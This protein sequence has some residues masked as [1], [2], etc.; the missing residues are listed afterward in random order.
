M[1]V[2]LKLF[3]AQLIWKRDN[4]REAIMNDIHQ[5]IEGKLILLDARR[6]VNFHGAPTATE[7]DAKMVESQSTA[8]SSGAYL[9]M[10]NLT[11]SEKKLYNSLINYVPQG[12]LDG[13]SSSQ[14]LAA[15]IRRNSRVKELVEADIA[16][17]CDGELGLFDSS[18][19]HV[20]PAAKQKSDLSDTGQSSIATPKPTIKQSHTTV[21][22]PFRATGSDSETQ[23]KRDIQQIMRGK[24][25]EAVLERMTNVLQMIDD[26]AFR[27][28]FSYIQKKWRVIRASPFNS[29][30]CWVVAFLQSLLGR[31]VTYKEVHD[32]LKTVFYPF[33]QWLIDNFDEMSIYN[34]TCRRY[35]DGRV[36]CPLAAHG[37]SDVFKTICMRTKAKNVMGGS[38]EHSMLAMLFKVSTI[39][40]SEQISDSTSANSSLPKAESIQVQHP[41]D[42][43]GIP[44][45]AELLPGVHMRHIPGHFDSILDVN[46]AIVRGEAC[47]N[48]PDVLRDAKERVIAHAARYSV[49]ALTE[50]HGTAF[51]PDKH[52]PITRRTMPKQPIEIEDDDDESVSL[53][54]M[55]IQQ[56]S[57]LVT[58]QKQLADLMA[59]IALDRDKNSG[60]NPGDRGGTGQSTVPDAETMTADSAEA[61]AA[62]KRTSDDTNQQHLGGGSDSANIASKLGMAMDAVRAIAN[63]PPPG[64]C[65]DIEFASIFQLRDSDVS[66]VGKEGTDRATALTG[67]FAQIELNFDHILHMNSQSS[68]TT[69]IKRVLQRVHAQ[70]SGQTPEKQLKLLDTYKPVCQVFLPTGFDFLTVTNL[71]CGSPSALTEEAARA[72][73][74][75]STSSPTCQ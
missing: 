2:P 61:D 44:Y 52:R 53:R 23:M 59:A 37:A 34:L 73:I 5:W 22:P 60:S 13:R 47:D 69:A 42:A 45:N 54:A 26:P 19:A 75:Y 31:E 21:G 10:E 17:W 30:L 46:G 11:R 72:I 68:R 74:A 48:L 36:D 15:I 7:D 32:F 8:D 3:L 50:K 9:T 38:V 64:H 43:P 14:A 6:K 39:S 16:K 56:A 33:A 66:P 18:K 24:P 51:S 35:D 40:H 27:R 62:A 49:E 63:P 58:M 20:P 25:D 70:M 12:G 65:D 67:A 71:T 29:N 41:W 55:V 57:N 4:N 1:A 28:S